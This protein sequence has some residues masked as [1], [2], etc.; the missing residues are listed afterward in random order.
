MRRVTLYTRAR[1]H[2][3]EVA[4]EVL[5]DV[6]EELPF[7][8]E[9]VDI[10]GDAALFARYRREIPVVLIDGVPVFR[11]RVDADELRALLIRGPCA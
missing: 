10:D 1:C 8:L 5:D 7:S 6:R 3:C 4:S 2:L 9:V 11:Y